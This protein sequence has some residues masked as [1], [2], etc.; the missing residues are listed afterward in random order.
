MKLNIIKYGV[1][2]FFSEILGPL[3]KDSIGKP[4]F[5]IAIFL[6][7]IF[8]SPQHYPARAEDMITCE[9]FSGEA[10]YVRDQEFAPDGF[11]GQ[12]FTL[13]HVDGEWDITG[14]FKSAREQGARV[15]Q[16]QL[17]DHH[18]TFVIIYD[19][20]VDGNSLVEIWT[21]SFRRPQAYWSRHRTN[22]DSVQDAYGTYRGYCTFHAN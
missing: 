10:F 22:N 7:F 20:S 19:G 15:I 12:S 2:S 16:V 5:C 18:S 6:L 4:F 1:A 14:T 21:F 3:K 11:T 13:R 17:N 8:I 9:R